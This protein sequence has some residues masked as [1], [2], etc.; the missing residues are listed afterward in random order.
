VCPASVPL[1]VPADAE[2][3]IEGYVNTDAGVIGLTRGPTGTSA[4]AAVFEGPFGDHTGFYSM[5]DRYPI[6]EV[7]AV[8]TAREA[9]LP[10]DDR[11]PAAA[12]GLL[13]GQGDGA[14]V[15]PAAADADP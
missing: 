14:G 9:D 3:V 7:T 15:P 13:P 10:D 8:T 6:V 1:W 4:R 5:P 2:I 12:G 11:R